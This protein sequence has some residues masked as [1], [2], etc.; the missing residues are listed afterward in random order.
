M[1]SMTHGSTTRHAN[2]ASVRRV[3]DAEDVVDL[4][5]ADGGAG[6]E[7]V[8]QCSSRGTRRGT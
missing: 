7:H 1:G 4:E 2:P 5:D 8:D 3:K 6:G